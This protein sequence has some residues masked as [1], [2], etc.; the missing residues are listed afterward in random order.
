MNPMVKI[1]MDR[2]LR[3]TDRMFEDTQLLAETLHDD[4]ARAAA[5]GEFGV[6]VM[7]ATKVLSEKLKGK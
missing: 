4:L 3:D 6:A 1:L 5:V 2:L 7:A